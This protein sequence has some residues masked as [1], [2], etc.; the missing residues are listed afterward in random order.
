MNHKCH[1]ANISFANSIALV[2]FLY[3]FA[4][5][6]FLSGDGEHYP[7]AILIPNHHSYAKM[8]LISTDDSV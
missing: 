7:S 6:R 4:L 5:V 3:F 1:L 2:E 8:I